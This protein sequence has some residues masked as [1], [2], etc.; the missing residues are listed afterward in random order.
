MCNKVRCDNCGHVIVEEPCGICGEEQSAVTREKL[1]EAHRK[2][3]IA[4][5][6]EDAELTGIPYMGDISE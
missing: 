1:R 3:E 6:H 2:K 5:Q 4:V